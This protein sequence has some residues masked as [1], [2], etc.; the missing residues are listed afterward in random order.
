MT[1]AGKDT[2]RDGLVRKGEPDKLEIEQREGE[3]MAGTQALQAVSPA[4]L[5]AT[6]GN[7]RQSTCPFSQGTRNGCAP[8]T[9]TERNPFV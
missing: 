5:V 8:T 1:K 2:P 9:T 7:P 4:K 6:T 3:A